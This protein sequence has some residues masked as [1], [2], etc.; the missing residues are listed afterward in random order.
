MGNSIVAGRAVAWSDILERRPVVMVSA[1]LARDYWQQP[2]QAIGKRVRCC[3]NPEWREIVGVSGDERDDGLNRPP[4]AIVYWPMNGDLYPWRAMAYAV[5]FDRVGT[6]GFQRE[7]EQAVWSVNP[8]LPLASVQTLEEIQ[9]NSMAKTSFTLVMLG[10]AAT[11]ALLLGIV[12][13]YGVISYVAAQ[14]TREIGIR[15]ALGA[16]V[17]DV[18]RLFLRHGLWLTAVGIAL[19][20]GLALVLTRMMS[21]YLFGVGP[22]DP[23]TYAIVSV[24]LAA[25][26]LLATYLPARRAARI[27]PNVALRADT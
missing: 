27:D 25:I 11:V 23:L 19:G 21:S 2:S 14:R 16:E 13:I 24:L 3:G 4:T 10:L 5:R 7:L 9:A 1:A 17:A 12:G 20:I 15:M 6:P 26:A 8:D 22:M 18:R